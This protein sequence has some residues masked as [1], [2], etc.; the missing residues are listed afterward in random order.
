MKKS[1]LF[2]TAILLA[3]SM[4]SCDEKVTSASNDNSQDILF[5]HG[6]NSGAAHIERAANSRNFRAHL[7][8]ESEVAD[9]AV[10]TQ[11]SGQA[12][13]Q[14]S[15]DSTSISYKLIVANIE[16]V[17]MAHIHLAPA[18]E[19]GPV[20]VW[21]YPSGPPPV[22][23]P[24]RSDGVLAEGVITEDSFT[25]A[26]PGDTIDDLLDEIRAGNTYVNVHT[27]QYPGGEIRGQIF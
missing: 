22:P 6:G 4:T 11:A 7:K 2:L 25:N 20:I 18:G 21:L 26:F 17:R 23:I 8:G 10:E 12:T 1:M 24:G 13:F 9:P 5:S 15:K 3:V 27:D 14:L 16:N 19:N